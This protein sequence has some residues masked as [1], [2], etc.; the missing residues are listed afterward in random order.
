MNKNKLTNKIKFLFKKM[1]G[2]T[3]FISQENGRE[4]E[5]EEGFDENQSHY[6]ISRL[7][8]K[9]KRELKQEKAVIICHGYRPV[10]IKRHSGLDV[11]NEFI[12]SLLEDNWIV[13][14]TSYRSDGHI[15]RPHAIEDVWKLGKYILKKHPQVKGKIYLE[16]TSMGLKMHPL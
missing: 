15:P 14:A 12:K 6:S 9:E 10:G 13:A 5:L 16:G 3:E 11:E 4:I 7:L 8:K 2:K 1:K